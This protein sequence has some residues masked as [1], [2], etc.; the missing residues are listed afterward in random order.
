MMVEPFLVRALLGGVGLALVAG[1]LG[2]FVVWRRM[3]YFGDALAHGALL[4]MALGLAMGWAL[5][6]GVVIVFILMA[7][8]L[9]WLEG[10]RR[11]AT[12][13]LLGL[14]AHAALASGLVGISLLR[15]ANVDL[16]GVLFGDILSVHTSDLMWIYGGGALVLGVLIALWRPLLAVTVHEE[17]AL[18]EGVPVGRV[19]LAAMLLVALVI[20][21]AMKIVGVL[22]ITALL[23]IPPAT[24]RHFARSPESMAVLAALFGVLAVLVGL[25]ASLFWDT[26]SGPSVVVAAAGL[27]ALAMLGEELLRLA[28]R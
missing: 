10:R 14:L 11:L 5:Q 1:P 24:A 17:V 16:M 2:C 27:F 21:M 12:D 9:S 7:G 8:L 15:G 23:I 20:V 13:T 28:H 6:A 26:P 3:A 25:T 19:R 22:L 18:A 4:G